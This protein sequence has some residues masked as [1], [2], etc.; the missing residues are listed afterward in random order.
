M[1]L[2]FFISLVRLGRRPVWGSSEEFPTLL[3]TKEERALRMDLPG[4]M[5]TV[6]STHTPRGL[7]ILP[8]VSTDSRHETESSLEPLR[9]CLWKSAGLRAED[10]GPAP[11]GWA[12]ETPV[13]FL[14]LGHSHSSDKPCVRSY[15]R[16]QLN[17]EHMQRPMQTKW[18]LEAD[19]PKII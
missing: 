2:I 8:S 4:T 13:S 5:D 10:K 7:H 16:N 3:V 18:N 17:T 15:E 11:W 1:G 12:T 9:L 14:F 6:V 19:E